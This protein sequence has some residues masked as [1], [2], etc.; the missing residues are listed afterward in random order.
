M[1]KTMIRDTRF[2]ANA[3]IT[4]GLQDGRVATLLCLPAS[5][6]GYW[7]AAHASNLFISRSALQMDRARRLG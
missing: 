2:P 4:K 5:Y 6:R 7:N 3:G 1:V